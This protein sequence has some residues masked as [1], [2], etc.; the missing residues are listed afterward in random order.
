LLI[1]I[2]VKIVYYQV[3]FNT[4]ACCIYHFLDSSACDRLMIHVVSSY[5]YKM[6]GSVNF[7][8]QDVP[9]LVIVVINFNL[10]YYNFNGKQKW[11]SL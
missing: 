2:K 10:H 9:E 3:A 7:V 4:S 1:D 6:L 5:H 11:K 8:P